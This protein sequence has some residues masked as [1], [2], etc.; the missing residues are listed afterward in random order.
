MLLPTP[1]KISKKARPKM[2][3]FKYSFSAVR[4][5]VLLRTPPKISKKARPEMLFFKY[6]FS[7]VHRK[8]LLP[9]PPKI[10]KK[11]RREMFEAQIKAKDEMQEM[12]K[13]QQMELQLQDPAT[14]AAAY[15]YYQQQGFIDYPGQGEYPPAAAPGSHEVVYQDAAGMPLSATY[16]DGTAVIQMPTGPG[17]SMA[18]P[19]GTLVEVLPHPCVCIRIALASSLYVKHGNDLVQ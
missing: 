11:A 10:S 17:I 12:V 18:V 13:Q 2:L 7:A 19:Q 3:F 14:A 4:R 16:Q 15:Q 5:K 1:P 8:V 6:S 9:T